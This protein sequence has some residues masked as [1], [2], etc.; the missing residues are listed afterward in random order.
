M[1]ETFVTKAWRRHPKLNFVSRYFNR[2]E[3]FIRGKSAHLFQFSDVSD[4]MLHTWTCRATWCPKPCRLYGKETRDRDDFKAWKG[5]VQSTDH[6]HEQSHFHFHTTVLR[7]SS[8]VVEHCCDA[9]QEESEFWTSAF[10]FEDELKDSPFQSIRA[11]TFF[12]FVFMLATHLCDPIFDRICLFRRMCKL[13]YRL[14]LGFRVRIK[15]VVS[16][17]SC[18]AAKKWCERRRQWR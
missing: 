4:T 13:V 11:N 17:G 14:V 1:N 5:A 12:S 9:E 16:Q 10:L 18:S 15:G 6:E 8:H 3:S 2:W 7:C